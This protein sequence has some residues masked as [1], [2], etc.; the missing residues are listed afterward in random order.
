MLLKKAL[1]TA[2]T[3]L[4]LAVPAAAMAQDYHGYYDGWRGPYRAE[5]W[6]G[7]HRWARDDRRE[8][9]AYRR[10]QARREA[11]WRERRHHWREWRAYGY[12]YDDGPRG[13]YGWDR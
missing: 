6:R 5:A 11:Y 9:W 8:Y 3:V 7:D 4:T 2:A 13:Y 10:E 12:R 1:L